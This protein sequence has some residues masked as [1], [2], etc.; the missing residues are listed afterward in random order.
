MKTFAYFFPISSQ[1]HI[2]LIEYY[3]FWW[4]LLVLNTVAINKF[5]LGSL[6]PVAFFHAGALLSLLIGLL[7]V[8]LFKPRTPNA[9]LPTDPDDPNV[10][11]ALVVERAEPPSTDEAD[12]QTPLLVTRRK[13]VGLKSEIY[14][15]KQTGGMWLWQYIVAVPF[16]V[17][18]ISQIAW[19]LLFGLNGT[20][21]DG[22]SPLL[23]AYIRFRHFVYR[24]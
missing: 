1:R 15:E 24:C 20:L 19:V 18:F 12:E 16:P 22:G 7:E 5:K 13:V 9:D 21:A 2:V 3:V 11:T 14:D 4:T 8:L 6:F 10:E 23:C 17:L